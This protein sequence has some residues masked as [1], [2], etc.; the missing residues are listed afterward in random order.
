MEPVIPGGYILLSRKLIDSQIMKKPPLYI[1]VWTWILLRA[2]HEKNQNLDRGEL[3]TSIKEIQEE[4]T[5]MV[6]YRKVTPS[7]KQIRDVL[8]WLRSP[9]E[10]TDEGSTK[11]NTK[12]GM[13]VTTKVTH[14][15]RIKVVNYSLYQDP[16]NY[17]GHNEGQKKGTTK[18]ARRATEGHN[19]NKNDK[20]VKNDKNK[21]IN[22]YTSNPKLIEVIND[23]FE[24]RKAAKKPMTEKAIKLLLNKLDKLADTDE[25]KIALLEQSI[26]RGW[27]S[28]FPLKDEKEKQKGIGS[29]RTFNNFKS[30]DYKP[31]ELE[32]KLKNKAKTGMPSEDE[33]NR[34]LERLMEERRKMK[35]E[36]QA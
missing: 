21:I 19:N 4:M 23:F 12:V 22:N 36:Q 24:M 5:W 1:K 30:R 9:Y 32:E 26:E 15:I 29:T 17:E 25:K 16:K 8:D 14:G 33:I 18:E 34:E 20:N 3:V 35:G 28:V 6:G 31:G 11:G 10:G 13:I 2:R 7:Y 27:L